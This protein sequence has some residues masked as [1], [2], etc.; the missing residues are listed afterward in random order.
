MNLANAFRSSRR[1]E[2]LAR[3]R[4]AEASGRANQEHQPLRTG[5][6]KAWRVHEKVEDVLDHLTCPFDRLPTLAAIATLALGAP[7]LH[8]HAG[9]ELAPEFTHLSRAAWINSPPL[10]LAQLRGKPV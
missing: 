9:K 10:T 3:S 6:A 8:A 1:R 7:T 4:V 5:F 2:R